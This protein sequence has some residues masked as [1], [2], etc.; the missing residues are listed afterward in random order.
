LEPDRPQAGQQLPQA[1]LQAAAEV[2][3]RP[4]K[5]SIW[6]IEPQ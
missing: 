3:P 5:V 4:A 6:K 2:Q 1:Q